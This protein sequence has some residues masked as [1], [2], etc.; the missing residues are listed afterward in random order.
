MTPL[1]ADDA[2]RVGL[3][4]AV[5]PGY[6]DMLDSA[7]RQ[8]VD[9]MLAPNSWPFR[10]MSLGRWKRNADLS[11]GALARARATELAQMS[12]DFWSARSQRYHE[13]RRAFVR[14]AKPPATPLRFATHRRGQSRLD[15]E[16]HDC[17]DSVEWFAEKSRAEAKRRLCG[18]ISQL[19]DEF[20]QTKSSDSPRPLLVAASEAPPLSVR[21]PGR[22]ESVDRTASSGL[23][24]PCYY[25]L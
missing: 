15:Q 7:I 21:V 2:L 20:S 3:V 14:K 16:E 5:V 6:G 13:R 8:R 10:N 24:F 22:D 1:S 25:T 12:M 4:D 18:Q 19:L 23:L 9:A 17:F 11:A